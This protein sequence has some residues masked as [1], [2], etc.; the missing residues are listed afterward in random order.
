MHILD[1][2]LSPRVKLIITDSLP[3]GRISIEELVSNEDEEPVVS[4]SEPADIS[5][6]LFRFSSP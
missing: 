3:P 5:E 6:L 2:P 1:P 4:T